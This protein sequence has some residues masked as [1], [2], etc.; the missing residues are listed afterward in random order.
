M[1]E[2][3]LKFG[4]FIYSLVNDF[5]SNYILKSSKPQ[6]N[7]WTIISSIIMENN[8][9]YKIIC[10]S[11][12]TKSLP[13]INYK[14]RKF[15]I[16]D[17]HSEILTLRCFKFFLL[18]ALSFHL[19]NENVSNYLT[20]EEHDL[21]KS[22]SEFYDIFE[23]DFKNKKF[24]IKKNINF[25]LYISESPCGEC[26]NIL[27]N[28][29]K[30]QNIKEMTGSKT[31]EECL[32]IINSNKKN[33]SV[34]NSEEN[35]NNNEINEICNDKKNYC[36]RSKSIRSDFK[37]NNLSYSLSCTDKIMFR[38]ILGYQGKYLSFFIEPIFIKSLI[39]RKILIY[40]K[41]A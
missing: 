27:Y 23:Y 30:Q 2:N 22:N 35:E 19:D 4:E 1:S 33:I 3:K 39:I 41:I 10:F 25:H 13:N 37:V 29:N 7:Q 40:L 6:S 11:N 16:F 12:G 26:S 8:N 34:K 17:C 21:F 9:N 24:Y 36:F 32:N 28:I 18:N 31:I 20:K 38:N 14:S 15:Q 5:Y